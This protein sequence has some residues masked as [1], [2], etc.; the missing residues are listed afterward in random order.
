[1]EDR[2]EKQLEERDNVVGA[3]LSQLLVVI[4]SNGHYILQYVSRKEPALPIS[5]GDAKYYKGAK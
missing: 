3:M 2:E 5:S 1:M 4:G